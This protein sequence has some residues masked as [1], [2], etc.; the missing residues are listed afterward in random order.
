VTEGGSSGS[1]I[2]RPDHDLQ[3]IGVLSN[4]PVH[5][6]PENPV[7]NWDRYGPFRLF[8]PTVQNLLLATDEPVE[9][10]PFDING[11]GVVDAVDIQLVINA[12]LGLDV[13]PFDAD[14]NGTGKVNA[15]DVQLVINAALG[16]G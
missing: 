15:V 13:A 4:G 1:P 2:I 9:P 12:A 11:D 16:H 6:C 8:F 14:I 7:S 10:T 5:V 3:I